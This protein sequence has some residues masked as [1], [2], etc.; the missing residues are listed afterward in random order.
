MLGY[1]SVSFCDGLFFFFFY[2]LG[3]W[4]R[5]SSYVMKVMCQEKGNWVQCFSIGRDGRGELSVPILWPILGLLLL[6]NAA[7]PLPVPQRHIVGQVW[8]YPFGACAKLFLPSMTPYPNF[9]SCIPW[10][11]RE[12]SCGTQW[13]C[14]SKGCVMWSSKC[15]LNNEARFPIPKCLE[16]MILIF[17]VKVTNKSNLK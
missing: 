9:T 2:V 1:F 12:S 15:F 17:K 6:P 7:E 16:Y 8:V 3:Y 14:N 5:G 13:P 10:L 11:L 4:L